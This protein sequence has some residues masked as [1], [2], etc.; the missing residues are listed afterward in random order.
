MLSAHPDVEMS[1]DTV[2]FF[3]FCFHRYDPISDLENVRRLFS[4]MSHR[5][6]NRFD[7]E[8]DVE[9]C[10][11]QM[12]T[13]NLSYGQAYSSILTSLF[14]S[15]NDSSNL[16]VGDKEALA[17]T[18]IPDFLRMCPNGKAIVILRDPRDVVTSFKHSTIAPGND[19]LIALFN[20]VD[21]VNHAFRYRAQYPDQ[22]YVA[23]FERLKLNTEDELKALCRF[24]KLDFKEGMLD[25]SNYTDHSG[26]A[27]DSS[28]S[29]TFTNETNWLAPVGRWKTRIEE[30]DLFLCQWIGGEQIGRLGLALD[31]RQFSREVFQ[32]AMDKLMSSELLQDAFKRWCEVGEGSE[33]FPLDPLKPSNWEQA[34]VNHPEAFSELPTAPND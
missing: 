29:L 9:D 16:R 15:H 28:E 31:A 21:A 20:V 12:G 5:L 14:S 1:Y 11:A 19:Y 22:V 7:I 30:E 32:R 23:P 34:A 8:L 18:K 4:D 3:R 24:L 26:A 27:W 33:K 25:A 13:D 2:N 17:W 6:H 10:M